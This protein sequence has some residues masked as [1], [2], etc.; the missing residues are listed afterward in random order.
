[1]SFSK[2]SESLTK[3][4]TKTLTGPIARALPESVRETFLLRAFGLLKIRLLF[5]IRPSV[6]EMTESRCE[7]RV[8]LNRRTRNHLHSM[9]FGTLAAGADCAGGLIAMRVIQEEGNRVSL[10]FKDFHAEF[11]KRAEGDVH[12]VCTEGKAVRELVLKALESGQRENMP[13]H[14]TAT[15]PS[16][17]GTEPVANF[18]LTLSLK[19]K[20]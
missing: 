20:G 1:M 13:V 11:L 3:A 2:A 14:I 4:L 8:P 12:F 16:K 15:V 7:I 17:L 18:I 9:Y 10:I 19:R 6:V 5:F